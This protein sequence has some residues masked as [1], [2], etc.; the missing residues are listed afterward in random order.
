[1]S[2]TCEPEDYSFAAHF[3]ILFFLILYADENISTKTCASIFI[4]LFVFNEL[5]EGGR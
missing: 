5:P 4:G 1:M 3:M 2:F